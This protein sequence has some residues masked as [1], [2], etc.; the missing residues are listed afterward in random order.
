MKEGTENDR[1]VLGAKEEK[2]GR[3]ECDI[4]LS[5]GLSILS[6]LCL[7]GGKDKQTL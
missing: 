7:E 4:L 1:F 3:N 2:G 5:F 6:L